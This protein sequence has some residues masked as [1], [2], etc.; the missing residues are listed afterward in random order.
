MYNNRNKFQNV[1]WREIKLS[2][3]HKKKKKNPDKN[4]CSV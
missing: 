2:E 4:T 3:L 1:N